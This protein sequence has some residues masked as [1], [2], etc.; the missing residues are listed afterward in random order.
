[1]LG[2]PLRAAELKSAKTD[3]DT[4]FQFSVSFQEYT[5]GLPLVVSVYFAIYAS[6]GR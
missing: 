3:N 5:V 4:I 2:R 6:S 1:M